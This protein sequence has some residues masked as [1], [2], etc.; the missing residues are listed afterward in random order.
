[1]R[2]RDES[3]GPFIELRELGAGV[4]PGTTRA[5]LRC[6]FCNGGTLGENSL[7]LSRPT[8]AEVL[9][10]CHRASCNRSGRVAARGFRLGQAEVGNTAAR[11]PRNRPPPRVYTGHTTGLGDR[12]LSYLLS[13]YRILPE[14]AVEAG[15]REEVDTGLMVLPLYNRNL[16]GHGYEVRKPK[17]VSPE[18]YF[19][20]KARYYFEKAESV[21]SNWFGGHRASSPVVVVEDS[22]SAFRAGQLF[23][24]SAI[25]GTHLNIELVQD[26]LA[27]S[28]E[29]VLALDQDATAKAFEYQ[30]EFSIYGNF[31]VA[32]LEQDLKYESEERIW[33]IIQSAS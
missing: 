7:S 24:S 8:E 17:W 21:R 30:K 4:E 19:R 1:M 31:R 3:A 32:Q 6:P 18:C 13:N 27:V 23:R 26:L 25:L 10:F 16:L 28:N 15:W 22:F 33:D 5:G 12:W 14:Q 11:R 20:G 9:Y 2:G 29:I